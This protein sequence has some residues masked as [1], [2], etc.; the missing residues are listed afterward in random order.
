MAIKK[1]APTELQRKLS[2]RIKELRM[3]QGLSQ[4]KLSINAGL[5]MFYAG[6]IERLKSNPSVETLQKIAKALD[7]SLSELL[8]D[9]DK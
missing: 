5:D 7:V 4:I 8:K 1:K 2:K 9:L 6:N 3:K